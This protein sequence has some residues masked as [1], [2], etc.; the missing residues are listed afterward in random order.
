MDNLKL[1]A[2]GKKN[3]RKE[4]LLEMKSRIES[5]FG[6]DS[7]PVLDKSILIKKIKEDYSKKIKDLENNLY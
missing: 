6:D 4:L 1:H 7:S 3:H 2:D 5:I